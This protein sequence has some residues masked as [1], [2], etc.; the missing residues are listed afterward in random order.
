L[1][2]LTKRLELLLSSDSRPLIWIAKTGARSFTESVIA[3]KFYWAVDFFN[4][5][6]H[7]KKRL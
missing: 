2:D 7:C 1:G 4:R 6:K 5:V 3:S